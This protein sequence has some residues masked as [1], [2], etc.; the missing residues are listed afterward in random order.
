MHRSKQHLQSINV[1]N[2][3][4]QLCR[5]R[6]LWKVNRI[7]PLMNAINKLPLSRRV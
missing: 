3:H 4:E 2:A 5:E 1:M 7:D 6:L